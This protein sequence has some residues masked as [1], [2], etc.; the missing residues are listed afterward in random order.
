L[1]AHW[2]NCRSDIF[3]IFGF[4]FDPTTSNSTFFPNQVMMRPRYR[5]KSSENTRF[6]G[7]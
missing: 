6:S 5:C 4:P 7:G 2:L 1:A 3:T